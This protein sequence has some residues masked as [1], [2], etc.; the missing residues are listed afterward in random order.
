MKLY[1]TPGSP[2]ARIVR[3]VILEKGLQD[4]V[5]IIQAQTRL[6]NS[7]YYQINP[8][9]RVPYL[10]RDDGV[11]MEE[12][13]FICDY[14]DRLSGAP[15]PDL[16]GHSEQWEARRLESLARS[17]MDGLAVWSREIGR[18]RNEQSPT[19]IAHERARSQRMT[20]L[21][22]REITRPWMHGPLDMAQITLACALGLEARI[23]EFRWR[24]GH[25][26]LCA[27]YE[28]IAARPSFQAT[29]PPGGH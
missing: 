23:P 12:S 11:G 17:M 28:P 14:L 18:P 1:I 27:W 10:V 24:D 13:A 26:K 8:S 3:V 25:P 5:E 9:G 29:V 6:A 22:E 21:W 15:G 2:Y 20:D 19:V 7:P 4:R 16:R